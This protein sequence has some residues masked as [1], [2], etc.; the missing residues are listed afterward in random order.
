MVVEEW[1]SRTMTMTLEKETGKG[2]KRGVG[3]FSVDLLRLW[4]SVLAHES[5]GI[6]LRP[7]HKGVIKALSIDKF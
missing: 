6:V 1:E 3:K 7:G 4:F 5:R 2:T